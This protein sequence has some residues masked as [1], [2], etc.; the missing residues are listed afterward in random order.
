MTTTSSSMSSV[1]PC[2]S[3]Q[4]HAVR[5]DA[6]AGEEAVEIC[7]QV[8]DGAVTGVEERAGRG[9]A[10]RDTVE[11]GAAIL[12]VD[13][14]PRIGTASSDW[15][16]D[17]QGHTDDVDLDPLIHGW[18]AGR[19]KR[20]VIGEALT[21]STRFAIRA[22]R[23]ASLRV[24]SHEALKPS[25]QVRG[26]FGRSGIKT[27]SPLSSTLSSTIINSSSETINKSWLIC[28][29]SWPMRMPSIRTSTTD[30]LG[31]LRSS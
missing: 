13:H 10:D 7:R 21:P 11:D 28:G 17:S 22:R 8:C 24:L 3:E 6:V 23:Y 4:P 31:R 26:H 12:G 18:N 30:R 16:R 25:M 27:S 5:P 19:T 15:L 1:R 14:A 20:F 29:V 2:P 9:P